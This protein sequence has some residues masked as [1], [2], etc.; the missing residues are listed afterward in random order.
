MLAVSLLFGCASPKQPNRTVEIATYATGDDY[1]GDLLKNVLDQHGIGVLFVQSSGVTILAV[2]QAEA[3]KAR[4]ILQ[5]LDAG[6]K[7]FSVIP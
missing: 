7:S 1:T 6:K 5:S 4:L 3:R 2:R